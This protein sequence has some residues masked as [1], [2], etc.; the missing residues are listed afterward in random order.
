MQRCPYLYEMKERL[1]IDKGAEEPLIV[2]PATRE[3]PSPQPMAT[4]VKVRFYACCLQHGCVLM[5]VSLAVMVR[6]DSSKC[7]SLGPFLDI[8]T[9]LYNRRFLYYAMHT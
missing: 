1:L 4:I 7:D 8:L 5:C 9:L 6:R 2:T 3:A